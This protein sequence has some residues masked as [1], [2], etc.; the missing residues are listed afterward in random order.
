[1]N[2]KYLSVILAA[3]SMAAGLPSVA[4]ATLTDDSSAVIHGT[5]NFSRTDD[6]KFFAHIDFAV[7]TSSTYPGSLSFPADKYIY[8]YQ[9]FNDTTSTTS[10]SSL[11]INVDTG[12]ID[13]SQYKDTASGSGAAGGK[14]P[15][16]APF[17][18]TDFISYNFGRNA[19]SKNNYSAVLLFTSDFNWTMGTGVVK[20]SLD[21]ANSSFTVN[22][23]IPTPEPATVLL[24][25]LASP[26]LLRIHRRRT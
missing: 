9:L 4:N 23:P 6:P 24:M 16:S 2:T 26:A 8:C 12:L 13:Y 19:F 3:I 22:I 7:Y 25:A 5:Q 17:D 11:T 15:Q 14:T 18:G 1:M 10:V 20:D 21:A